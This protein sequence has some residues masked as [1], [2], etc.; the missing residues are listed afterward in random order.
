MKEEAMVKK[1]KKSKFKLDKKNAKAVID[2]IFEYYELELEDLAPDAEVCG[3]DIQDSGDED[4]AYK[5]T[6]MTYNRLVRFAMRGRIEIED[7]AEFVIVQHFREPLTDGRTTIKW[8][9]PSGS[10]KSAMK[11]ASEK[12]A[13][14]R[15]LYFMAALC[16]NQRL[17][18][19]TLGKL[20]GPDMSLMECLAAVFF[21]V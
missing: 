17:D 11:R 18:A 10:A 2:E 15:M 3:I 6:K 16:P 9:P 7:G 20:T 19:N 12:D 4:E 8:S 21:L 5:A 1:K 13:H 14:G